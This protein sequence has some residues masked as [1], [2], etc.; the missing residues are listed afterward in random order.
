MKFSRILPALVIALG[1]SAHASDFS[2]QSQK[3][4]LIP[5]GG[6]FKTAPFPSKRGG[7]DFSWQ[8]HKEILLPDTDSANTALTRRQQAQKM[9]LDRYGVVATKESP[10][11]IYKNKRTKSLVVG[12]EYAKAESYAEKSCPP[13]TAPN[14]LAD[15]R[16]QSAAQTIALVQAEA[17]NLASIPTATPADVA[18]AKAAG[19]APKTETKSLSRIAIFIKG[20]LNFKPIGLGHLKNYVAKVSLTRSA[21]DLDIT[22][23]IFGSSDKGISVELGAGLKVVSKTNPLY[24]KKGFY[25]Y[26][27]AGLSYRTENLEFALSMS[28]VAGGDHKM[29]PKLNIGYKF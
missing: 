21:V 7:S 22:K 17:G 24:R 1:A 12:L 14:P 15:G 29:V 3:S 6:D 11:E 23:R 19:T 2:W 4:N 8:A 27:V 5:T 9:I 25:F 10:E 16:C 18:A 26:G 20:T 13:D 28:K